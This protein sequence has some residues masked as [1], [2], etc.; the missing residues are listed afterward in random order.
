M[1]LDENAKKQAL[2]M[3]PYGLYVVGVKAA[4]GSISAFT[5]N[6]LSQASFKP[7]LVMLAV[8]TDS[9]SFPV[10]RECGKF[11]VSILEEG[12]KAVA[13]TFFKKPEY[14]DG[15]LAGYPVEFH[16]TGAP[17]LSDAPAFVECEVRDSVNRG[18]H[19]VIVAEVIN[20]GRKRDAKILNL[21]DTGWKY[22]G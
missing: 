8:K 17:V 13:G 7:P 12:Q 21:A 4:D 9:S 22:G 11:S 1:S 16:S 6:W 19:A 14:V 5:A 2:L 3:I 20:A 18:D 15:K 10:I